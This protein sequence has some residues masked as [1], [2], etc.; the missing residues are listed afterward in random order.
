MEHV[1][2]LK[3]QLLSELDGIH[4]YINNDSHTLPYVINLGFPKQANDLLLMRLDLAGIL[5]QL[6][7]LVQQVPL[8]PVMFLK[9]CR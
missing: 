4:Y 8:S 6:A 1:E 5:S 3:Q 2:S 7:L 9:L